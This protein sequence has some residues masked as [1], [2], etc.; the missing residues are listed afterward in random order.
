MGKENCLS[1]LLRTLGGSRW[2]GEGWDP[3]CNVLMAHHEA[4]ST[5]AFVSVLSK[6]ILALLKKILRG[7][8]NKVEVK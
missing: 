2:E 6:I 1:L 5:R 7:T 8:A 3:Q 4:E